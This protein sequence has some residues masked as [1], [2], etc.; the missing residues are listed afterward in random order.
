M[1]DRNSFSATTDGQLGNVRLYLTGTRAV[2]KAAGE[3]S[4]EEDIDL[5]P[6]RVFVFDVYI[7][8]DNDGKTNTTPWYTINSSGYL[9]S[10]WLPQIS[11]NMLTLSHT[12]MHS[13]DIAR[14]ITTIF[15]YV[16]YEIEMAT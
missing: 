1:S 11:D 12:A 14:E 15:K 16:I 9:L 13:D 5:P 4:A 10:I 7:E 2:T 8:V 6:G 3:S